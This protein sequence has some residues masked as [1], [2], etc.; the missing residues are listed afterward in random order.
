MNLQTTK[1]RARWLPGGNP[2][3]A[4]MWEIKH[5]LTSVSV[6]SAR[7]HDG[8]AHLLSKYVLPAHVDLMRSER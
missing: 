3:V 5:P 4:H 7:P 8:A 2:M 1:P 6:W